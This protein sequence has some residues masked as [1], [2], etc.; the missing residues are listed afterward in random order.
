MG[1]C[2]FNDKAVAALSQPF[3]V[4]GWW[5]ASAAAFVWTLVQPSMISGTLT[6]SLLALAYSSAIYERQI[7]TES[8][9]KARDEAL[10]SKID[11]LIRAVPEADTSLMHSEPE[12]TPADK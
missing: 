4:A 5:V 1:L 2:E 6:L 3:I 11:E 8:T 7:R 10:H 9:D 12:L